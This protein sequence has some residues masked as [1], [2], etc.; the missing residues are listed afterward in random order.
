MDSLVALSTGIAYV[1]S[2]FNTL[3]PQYWHSRGL[4]PHVY[5]EA[6]V[7]IIFFILLGKWLEEKAKSNTSN[8]IKKLIGLQP[9]TVSLLQ[10]DNTTIQVPIDQIKK[11]DII[12]VKP[13][14]K[15]PV[16]GVV[17]SGESFVDESSI[18]GEPIPILKNI[19]TKVFTGTI[20]QKGTINISAQKV[21]DE[22]LLAQI[23]KMVQ[24]AQG[25]KAPIQKNVDK[26]ASVFVPTVMMIALVTF[27]VWM[28]SGIENS[29]TYGLLSAITVLV[30]ACPC[31]LGLATPTA[32]MVGIG[33]GAQLGILI[34][35]AEALELSKNINAIILDKT[36]TI[37]E[38][39]PKVE[40]LVW[41]KQLSNIN[42]L[43][44]ILFSIESKSEHP[45]AQSV[46]DYLKQTD[47]MV[48]DGFENITGK[49][50]KAHV[51]GVLYFVG[52]MS[53]M[54]DMKLSLSDDLQK[55]FNDYSEQAYT[56]F[57]FSNQ[58][59]VF[60]LIAITDKIK[61][62][63]MQAIKGLQEMGIEVYMLTGDSEAA[64]K[65]VASKTGIK[66]YKSS[67]MPQDKAAFTKKLQSKGK[68]VAMVGDGINDS[69]ALAQADVSFAMAK[70][71]DIAMDVAK[72]TIMSSDLMHLLKAIHLSRLTVSKIRQNL[73]WA[74][75][76]NVIGIPLAAGVLFPVN[77]FLLNPMIAGGAMALSSVSV[78][79]N[80][81]LLKFKKI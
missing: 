68:V 17:V 72:V 70:G 8:A 76:Y 22:T 25:S 56:V 60:A 11:E 51:N 13:G 27:I 32:I 43:T 67:V 79:T 16:D 57:A 12:V 21:G 39:K 24:E 52:S 69:N 38:G 73:F 65:N 18:N 46:C 81:L 59:D 3:N 77:G 19:N 42:E 36:G 58:Q 6:S 7:V 44:Q 28:V 33:K 9:K 20:N 31:A 53:F 2:V 40:S 54:N 66:L 45:L 4:H 26:I 47:A 29:F 75:I 63:S 49:G 5:F 50:V 64:A 74:F 35:D 15:I 34:K 37:T 30:I 62:T 78:V 14:D 55:E 1:F 61:E 71:S 23:I 10:H 48:I 80:S 41:N